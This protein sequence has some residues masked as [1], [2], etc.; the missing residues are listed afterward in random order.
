VTS[1]QNLQIPLS[2]E[3]RPGRGG[4]IAGIQAVARASW[5]E[6]YRDIFSAESIDAFLASAY[7]RISLR[8]ALASKKAT[9]LVA[10]NEGRVLGYSQFGDRGGG[11]ELFR[12]YVEPRWWGRGI[13]RRLLSHAEMQ[14]GALGV[15]RY[16]LT[17]HRQNERAKSFYARR[18][19]VHHAPRDHDDEWYMVKVLSTPSK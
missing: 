6:A 15:R 10:Q 17:L 7:S 12:L 16:F 8:A 11:P 4:D 14:F 1:P 13:G 3:I 5:H 2:F 9:F 19:F 18:G